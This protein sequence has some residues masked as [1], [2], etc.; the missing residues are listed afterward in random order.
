[1]FTLLTTLLSFS[2][3][4]LSHLKNSNLKLIRTEVYDVFAHVTYGIDNT[5]DNTFSNNEDVITLKMRDGISCMCTYYPGQQ[6]VDTNINN[7]TFIKDIEG[8]IDYLI[9]SYIENDRPNEYWDINPQFYSC[10]LMDGFNKNVWLISD[11]VGSSPLWYA[12][13]TAN[14]PVGHPNDSSFCSFI[15]TSDLIAAK[16]L[17]FNHLTPLGSGQLISIDITSNEIISF[18]NWKSKLNNLYNNKEIEFV[19]DLKFYTY[20]IF[21]TAL[22]LISKV[23]IS[24]NSNS[25]NKD[26]LIVLELD[27]TDISSIFTY[28][29]I[30]SLEIPAGIKKV[31]VLAKNAMT[32]ES[33]ILQSILEDLGDPRDF[34]SAV[35]RYPKFNS[36]ALDRWNFC[37]LSIKRTAIS[38]ITGVDSNPIEIYLQNLL[39]AVQKSSII[40]VF[41]D[42]EF[43]LIL[44]STSHPSSMLHQAID[45]LINDN[46]CNTSTFGVNELNI[47]YKEDIEK[48]ETCTIDSGCFDY[49]V[50]KQSNSI[51]TNNDDK[52]IGQLFKITSKYASADGKIILVLATSGYKAM[53]VNFLC[54]SMSENVNNSHIIVLTP[55][56]DIADLV[57]NYNVGVLMSSN[58]KMITDDE[59]NECN[60]NNNDNENSSCFNMDG[61]DISGASFGSLSYQELMY[62]RTDTVMKLLLLGFHPIIA[63]IDTVWKSDPFIVLNEI[64]AYRPDATDEEN[65]PYDIAVTDDNGEICGC[66]ISIMS[67]N[68][69][70]L[71]WLTV[72][73]EHYK[74]IMH[75]RN[76]KGFL[77][78][79]FDSEQKIITS[80]LLGVGGETYNGF[81]VAKVLPSYLFPSG[82][83]YFNLRKHIHAEIK[84][85]IIH[86]NFIV[87]QGIKKIRFERY[88]LWNVSHSENENEQYVCGNI[89]EKWNNYFNHATKDINIPL[90]SIIVPAHNSV[91]NGDK[92][93]VQ[94][95]TEGIS[96]NDKDGIL[97]PSQLWFER[98]PPS[99]ITFN[100]LGIYSL[101][102][103]SNNSIASFTSSFVN[104][105]LKEYVDIGI[106]RSYFAI[107]RNGKHH[108]EANE[109]ILKN[110]RINHMTH[111]DKDN[112]D[113][114]VDN[115]RGKII[116]TYSVKI[117]SFNRVLSLKRLL[118]SL[119]VADYMG[120]NVSMDIY[121]DYNRT[122]SEGIQVE[123]VKKYLNVFTW[124]FGLLT[125]IYRPYN[126]GLEN[127]WYYAWSPRRD[128]EAA[129][130]F[131]DDIVVSKYF[132]WWS[133]RTVDKYYTKNSKQYKNHIKLLNF[134][135]KH[136]NLNGSYSIHHNKSFS[137][138]LDEYSYITAGDPSIYGVCLQKQHLD[139]S[140]YPKKLN[141]KNSNQPFLYSLIGS[142]GPLL[143]P[144]PWLAFKEWWVWKSNNFYEH[145]LLTESLLVNYFYKKNPKIW[146]PWIVR[147]SFETGTKC[148]YSNLPNNL[149]LV[150]NFRE[151][152]ENYHVTEGTL[153]FNYI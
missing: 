104:S 126:I 55:N 49:S 2:N 89:N 35:V 46:V 37:K 66:F 143:L 15:I 81:I 60:D 26:S 105:N 109:K 38:Y 51:S 41:N 29:A 94:T 5:D 134:T 120:Y 21:S 19:N 100:H 83:Q 17:G 125:L 64:N 148:L 153:F 111:L 101:S 117:L 77:K 108:I 135:R 130:I 88:N 50:G 79:A 13:P 7:H 149:S 124:P 11:T 45:L 61:G 136:I 9:T 12:L 85:V 116:M 65:E 1:M 80:L 25:N 145:E 107:D 14:H 131:E 123:E 103:H 57:D 84:P 28:C 119:L 144:L 6:L 43:Q 68:N 73:N 91:S 16:R 139:P 138:P 96:I 112:N 31:N 122:I 151:S 47:K 129:F 62:F 20:K 97:I 52:F 27:N 76:N 132:F 106:N 59:I 127:S 92:E 58:W 44:M 18:N 128:D 8:T 48:D 118:D 69:A 10:T 110:K 40:Y 87:G 24:N 133:L 4:F 93:M 152:G 78:L 114:L 30:D 3:V 95:I 98:D 63:D 56:Q 150:T 82:L 39:C 70:K 34:S 113:Y 147:F 141:I 54:S 115:D 86:N 99:S 74:V 102:M 36:I 71:F 42:Y 137:S 23:N 67:N 75:G 22:N 33:S 32:Q 90:L 142:W 140:H 72:L 146:T 121:V 53:L